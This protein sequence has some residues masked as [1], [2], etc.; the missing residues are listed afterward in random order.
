MSV[1]QQLKQVLEAAFAPEHLMVENE[2]HQHAVPPD[3]ETHFK[4]T[5]VSGAFEGK[6]LVA[7]HQA[8][9]GVVG[10]ALKQ[11][12]HALALHTYTPDEWHARAEA[13][14]ESPNCL[15]GSRHEKEHS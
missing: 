14:P 12:V 13:A 7:R 10:E 11:G 8:V 5:L 9:Y 4:V 1:Q 2:S 15:G 3:S 6:R